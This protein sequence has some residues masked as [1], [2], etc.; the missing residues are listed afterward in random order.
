MEELAVWPL[1]DPGKAAFVG[2]ADRNHLHHLNADR[3]WSA[4]RRHLKRPTSWGAIA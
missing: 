4:L 1:S 2:G 3:F